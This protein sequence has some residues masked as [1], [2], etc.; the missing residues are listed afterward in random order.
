MPK[1]SF[2]GIS[3][4]ILVS[5]DYSLSK[6]PEKYQRN[7]VCNAANDT[8]RRERVR[9]NESREILVRILASECLIEGKYSDEFP[10]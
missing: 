5:L 8:S 2:L 9:T 7:R 6:A 1:C 4:Q 3:R 10:P